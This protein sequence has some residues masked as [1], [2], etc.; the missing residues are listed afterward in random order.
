[1]MYSDEQKKTALYLCIFLGWFGIHRFYLKKYATGLIWMFTGGL[2]F[3]GWIIDIVTIA[4]GKMF[5]RDELEERARE[6]GLDH[7]GAEKELKHLYSILRD[8][9]KAI[10]STTGQMDGNVWMVACTNQRV[11]FIDKG[12]IYGTKQHEILL[13]NITSISYR[14]ELI[15]GNILI[16]SYGT[17]SEI[18]NVP[19]KSAEKFVSIVNKEIAKI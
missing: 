19:K 1:M 7:F 10:Y 9:E 15:N 14:T 12:M 16:H 2:F 6:D 8:G 4:S 11:I 3:V 18:R 5:E 17:L 13:R